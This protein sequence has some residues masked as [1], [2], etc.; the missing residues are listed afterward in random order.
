M[1]EIE[2]LNGVLTKTGDIIGGVRKDQS[3]QPTPCDKYDVDA[4]MNHMTGWIQVFEAGSQGRTFDGDPMAFQHG[5]DPAREFRTAAAGVVAGWREHGLDRKVRLG[6]GD[7]PGE[8]AFNMTLMEYMTHGTDLALATG[9]TVPYT[10]AEAAETLA[11]AERTLP[12]EYRG[13]AFRPIV[14]I[15]G[16]APAVDRL[17]AFLGRRPFAAER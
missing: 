17:H 16:N 2:L 1:D 11:R 7:T 10:E 12:E 6:G 15:A 3:G 14:P 5:E 13:D 4:L 9:Q 8:M